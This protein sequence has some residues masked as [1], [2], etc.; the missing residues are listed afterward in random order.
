MSGKIQADSHQEYLLKLLQSE[1]LHSEKSRK[2]KFL[3]KA[4]FYAIKMILT[5]TQ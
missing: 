3:K 1:I 5:K 2:A 4:G